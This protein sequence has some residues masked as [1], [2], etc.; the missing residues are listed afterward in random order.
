MIEKKLIYTK[1]EINVYNKKK[2]FFCVIYYYFNI[3]IL[4]ADLNKISLTLTGF[5]D[6]RRIWHE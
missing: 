1:K 4:F 3:C 5:M 2:S 6:G